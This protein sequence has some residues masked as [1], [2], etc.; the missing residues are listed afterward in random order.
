MDDKHDGTG[1]FQGPLHIASSAVTVAVKGDELASLYRKRAALHVKRAEEIERR[2]AVIARKLKDR[3]EQLSPEDHEFLGL[4]P[5]MPGTMVGP[6][7]AEYMRQSIDSERR[8][9]DYLNFMADHVDVSRTFQL[10]DNEVRALI[11]PGFGPPGPMVGLGG[12]CC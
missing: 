8:M 1:L 3:A 6:A 11:G 7:N 5:Q 9:V 2:V 4:P 12:G 10:G